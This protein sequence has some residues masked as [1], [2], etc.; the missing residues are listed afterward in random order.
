MYIVMLQTSSAEELK[1]TAIF[2]INLI[3]LHV[4]LNNFVITL[5]LE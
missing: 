2:I 3:N 4:Y 5:L 1:Q